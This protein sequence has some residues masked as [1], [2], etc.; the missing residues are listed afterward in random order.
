M[1]IDNYK[2]VYPDLIENIRNGMH[3]DDLSSGRNI[4]IPVEVIKQK[5]RKLFAKG[6][7]HKWHW[8]I[9]LLEQSGSN[10]NDEPVYAKQLFPNKSNTKIV[11]LGRN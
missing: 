2:S 10:N 3:E 5:S 11:D 8:D 1:H 9:S 4:L 6:R 7:L